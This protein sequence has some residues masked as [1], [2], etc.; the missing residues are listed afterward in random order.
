LLRSIGIE[1]TVAIVT[2]NFVQDMAGREAA[3]NCDEQ[4]PT[5]IR[6]GN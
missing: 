1:F 3:K 5:V 2:L 4:V 6:L